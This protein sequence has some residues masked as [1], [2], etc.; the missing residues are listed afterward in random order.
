MQNHPANKLRQ[1]KAMREAG[2]D[3]RIGEWPGD[4]GYEERIANT[5][6]E[7]VE[8]AAAKD[9]ECSLV[10]EVCGAVGVLN[11]LLGKASQ[12]G[13]YVGL[14]VLNVNTR[15]DKARGRRVAVKCSRVIK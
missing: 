6:R 13:I 9:K 2:V 15:G 14:E 11:D 1:I 12:Y 3:P 7:C 5:A 10:E 4:P 8:A